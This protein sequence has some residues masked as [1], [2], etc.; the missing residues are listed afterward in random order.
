MNIPYYNYPNVVFILKIIIGVSILLSILFF[1]DI[2]SVYK[3]IV[4]VGLLN[5]IIILLVSLLLLL[6]Q[7]LRLHTLIWHYTGNFSTTLKLSF[8]G[9]FFSSFLPGSISGDI[10]K[11]LFLKEQKVSLVGA[12]SLISLDR[13]VGLLWVLIFGIGYIALFSPFHFQSDISWDTIFYSL[14]AVLLS[15]LSLYISY[16]KN[17]YFHSR[18]VSFTNE[19][20]YDFSLISKKQQCYFLLSSLGTFL[21]RIFKFY[22]ISL[23]FGVSLNFSDFFLVVFL[24]QIAS[25]IPLT[26][27]GLG[28]IEVSLVYALSLF[29][30]PNETGLAIALINRISMWLIALW[31]GIIW[32]RIK[33]KQRIDQ[34]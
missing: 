17:S 20:K 26:I 6:A 8:V 5:F 25:M 28:V 30:V 2:S 16:K 33:T 10:Y 31:G 12:S 3:T 22:I 13:L 27:G 9:Q 21:V 1:V 15:V 29:G 19:I 7:S 11:I 34:V 18:L 4:N 24:I 14:L 32:L 23:I